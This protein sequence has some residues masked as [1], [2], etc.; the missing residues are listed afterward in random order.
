[1]NESFEN[2]LYIHIWILY[3]TCWIDSFA[4]IKYPSN[5]RPTFILHSSTN[6]RKMLDEMLDWFNSA[7]NLF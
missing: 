5:T 2:F 6:D 7:F 3:E 1:M 4:D